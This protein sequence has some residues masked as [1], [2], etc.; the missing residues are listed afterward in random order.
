MFYSVTFDEKRASIS[1][2][3]VTINRSPAPADVSG[4]SDLRDER[5]KVL[6][7]NRGIGFSSIMK[8]DII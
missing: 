1:C 5:V 4:F 8:T 6:K 7:L 2:E 3:P